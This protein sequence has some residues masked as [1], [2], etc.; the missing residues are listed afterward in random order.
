MR[1]NVVQYTALHCTAHYVVLAVVFN[2]VG[3]RT[4]QLM[5]SSFSSS[6]MHMMSAQLSGLLYSVCLAPSI[7]SFPPFFPL[8]NPLYHPLYL[9]FTSRSF[10][11]RHHALRVRTLVRVGEQQI[12]E[13]F[14][15]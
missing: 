4:Q 14:V 6:P 1:G 15:S 10:A 13:T 2:M 8:S 11:V 5:C 7:L 3:T 9:D 12:V